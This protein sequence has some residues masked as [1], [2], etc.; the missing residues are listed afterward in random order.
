MIAISAWRDSASKPAVLIVGGLLLAVATGWVGW[1]FG[2]IVAAAL[3]SLLTVRY[4]S[5]RLAV[6]LV[7]GLVVLSVYPRARFLVGSVPLY[8]LDLLIAAGLAAALWGGRMRASARGAGEPLSR[9]TGVLVVLLSLAYLP[10]FLWLL[11]LDEESLPALVYFLGRYWLNTWVFFLCLVALQ[12]ESDIKRTLA[13]L[14]VG[15]F[16]ASIWAVFQGVPYLT[17]IGEAV[18]AEANTLFGGLGYSLSPREVGGLSLNRVVAGHPIATTWGG[19]YALVL[20]LLLFAFTARAA[21]RVWIPG[22][23]GLVLMSFGFLLT[24]ARGAFIAAAIGC[25][26][27]LLV[28]SRDPAR[29]GAY[30]IRGFAVLLLVAISVAVVAPQ[31]GELAV[32]RMALVLSPGEDPNIRARLDPI[33]HFFEALGEEPEIL[34]RGQHP[35]I[36]KLQRYE[37]L[38]EV[39]YRGFISNSWLLL[40]MEGGL[41]FFVLY[42]LIYL[43]ITAQLVR[44]IVARRRQGADVSLELGCLAAMVSAGVVHGV[45]NYMAGGGAL[46]LRAAYFFIAGL[47]VAVLR[48]ALLPSSAEGVNLLGRARG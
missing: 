36:R 39:G 8:W 20:P 43:V 24:Y 16:V 5:R 44:H 21:P 18:T 40:F 33:P 17:P 37:F 23:I 7:L 11:T 4:L 12:R 19:F 42:A 26:T 30:I 28:G 6:A 3:A 1:R 10:S 14:Y 22:R 27:A 34:L 46:Y 15:T 25:G 47:S 32:R 48:L 29:L 45:D 35:L 41:P 38:E 9:L 31:A 2:A 13:A